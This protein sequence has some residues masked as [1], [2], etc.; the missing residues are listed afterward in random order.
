MIILPRQA[1]DKQRENSK[2]EAFS[3]RTLMRAL[4][5][6]ELRGNVWIVRQRPSGALAFDLNEGLLPGSDVKITW[7]VRKASGYDPELRRLRTVRT[8][9]A[10]PPWPSLGAR[11]F[12]LLPLLKCLVGL[13]LT[14]YPTNCLV[15][16]Q[17]GNATTFPGAK[18]HDTV[19]FDVPSTMEWFFMPKT[20][21]CGESM[22][23]LDPHV[24]AAGSVKPYTCGKPLK[25]PKGNEYARGVPETF[26]AAAQPRGRVQTNPLLRW[27]VKTSQAGQTYET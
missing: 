17:G 11:G 3:Y 10:I 18:G 23:F 4:L 8:N 25:N 2:K 5:E 16:P 26:D 19:P 1:R 12:C 15:R 22:D 9:V 21:T 14:C 27:L 24:G 20:V 7:A 6:P 13:K